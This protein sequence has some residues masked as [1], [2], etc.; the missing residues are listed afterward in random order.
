MWGL[1]GSEGVE[2][3]RLAEHLEGVHAGRTVDD[4]DGL[5]SDCVH[6]PDTALHEFLG[7]EIVLERGAVLGHRWGYIT[8]TDYTDYTE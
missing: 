3:V 7:G 6:H 5:G 8:A 4:G 1:G 2:L